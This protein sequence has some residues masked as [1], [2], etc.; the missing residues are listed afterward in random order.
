M[1]LHFL[2]QRIC[3][4]RRDNLKMSFN[5]QVLILKL[6][7]THN[8]PDYTCNIMGKIVTHE[9]ETIENDCSTVKCGRC[10]LQVLCRIEPKDTFSLG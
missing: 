8:A 9:N 2:P 10:H 7:F 5:A 1:S 3:L 4:R 6:S